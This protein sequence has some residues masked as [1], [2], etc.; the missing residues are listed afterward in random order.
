MGFN[1]EKQEKKLW[2]DRF[3]EL[4]AY[5]EENG[6]FDVLKRQSTL[7]RWLHN[8]RT[9]YKEGKLLP[10]RTARLE[11]IGFVL[12][13]TKRGRKAKASTTRAQFS[14]PADGTSHN[15]TVRGSNDSTTKHGRAYLAGIF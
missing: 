4:V 14:L 3:N 5:K 15:D 8:Q 11:G 10:E 12:K 2:E 6:N 1:W 13:T 9:N 7:G